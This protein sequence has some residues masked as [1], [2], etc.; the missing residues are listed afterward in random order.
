MTSI[1][2]KVAL[3]AAMVAGAFASH[4]ATIGQPVTID[5]GSIPGAPG[6]IIIVDQLSGQ[7]DE[8]LT[9]TAGTPT[10]GTF[11]TEAIF[12]AGSWFFNSQSV[13]SLA[14]YNLYAKFQAS[15]SYT[16]SGGNTFNFA[17]GT[18][19]LELWADPNADTNY[20]VAA[21]SAGNFNNLVLAGGSTGDDI[22]LGVATS[23]GLNSGNATTGTGAN[24]N[25]EIIFTNFALTQPAGENY[26]T[27]PRPFYMLLDLNGNFQNIQFD[28]NNQANVQILN[29]S[30]NAFFLKVPEPGALALA[31]LAVLAAGVA[32]RRRK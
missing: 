5:E 27:A 19:A 13:K 29:S 15:G 3:A 32:S 25:F 23:T 14:T 9:F 4:A 26:F 28:P 17:G 22:K 20:D 18:G 16:I 8:V 6:K 24:G 30:A 12:N 1:L 21:T 31:G 2:K 11:T 7:Y 10:S